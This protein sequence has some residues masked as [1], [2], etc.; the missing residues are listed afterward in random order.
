MAFL[1]LQ[2]MLDVNRTEAEQMGQRVVDPMQK[3]LGEAEA[4]L[5]AT[6]GDHQDRNTHALEVMEG[7]A[8]LTNAGTQGGRAAA[9][10]PGA[11]ALDGFLAGNSNAYGNVRTKYGNLMDRFRQTGARAS[12]T[13]YRE[14][15]GGI[16]GNW[17]GANPAATQQ[18]AAAEPVDPELAQ[19]KKQQ[20]TQRQRGQPAN[21]LK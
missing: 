3:E 2:R 16:A 4:A 1:N 14:G 5:A 7:Q 6:R 19:H 20:K 15:A 9:I 13:Q 11:S 18:A 21:H 10:G 17:V 8:E 12:N